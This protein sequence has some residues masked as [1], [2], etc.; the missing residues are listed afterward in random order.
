[1]SSCRLI[2]CEKTSHW[3]VA[4]RSALDGPEPQ[5]VETRSLAGCEVALGQSP[6]SLVA[7]ETTTSN[8]EAVV[9]FVLRATSRFPRCVI[10][11]LLAPDALAAVSPLQ[12]AGAIA[13]ASSVLEAPRL[14][15]L[16]ARQFTHSP[17]AELG[18]R[19]FA[20][21]RM[22]WAAHATG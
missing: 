18:L 21:R 15:R 3:A 22:P 4:L 2:T 5:L 1:M 11:G 14:V 17:Q 20:E 13:V 6:A 7:I 12:E 8:V 19:E 16:A 9:D 10:V